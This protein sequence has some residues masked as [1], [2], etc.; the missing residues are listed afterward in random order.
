MHPHKSN[1]AAL[2][3]IFGLFLLI[4]ILVLFTRNEEVEP[5]LTNSPTVNNEA[6]VRQLGTADTP[7]KTTES[8]E[9]SGPTPSKPTEEPG[10]PIKSNYINYS[11][12]A[13]S[14]ILED[15]GQALLFFHA[16]WCPTCRAADKSIMQDG[17]QLPK[18]L[19]ILKTDYDSETDLK[20]KYKIN[21]QHTFVLVNKSGEEIKKWQGGGVETILENIT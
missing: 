14:Q 20:R 9:T 7:T 5:E 18:G 8:I 1:V 4:G 16:N 19:T 17:D 6:Q 21:Y 3:S 10:E 12:T 13:L 15:E 2:A 11:P